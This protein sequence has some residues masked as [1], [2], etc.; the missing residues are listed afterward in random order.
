MSEGRGSA[1]RPRVEASLQSLQAPLR[2]V[3]G[4]TLLTSLLIPDAYRRLLCIADDLP[5]TDPTFPS[6]PPRALE[7]PRAWLLLLVLRID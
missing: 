5:R 6:N 3:Q 2:L 4:Q 7:I 1:L